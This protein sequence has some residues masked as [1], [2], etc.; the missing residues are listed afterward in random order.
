MISTKTLWRVITT[1]L[2]VLAVAGCN[3]VLRQFITPVPS[4]GGDP[5]ALSHAVVLSTNPSGNGSD[6]H[7]DVSGD[8]VAGVVTVGP[9]PVFLGKSTNQVFVLNGDNTVTQ[10]F[11]LNVLGAQSP[12]V[13]TLPSGTVAEGGGFSNSGNFYVA[14]GAGSDVSVIQA[15]VNAVTGTV[16][17]G[18]RPVAVAGNNSS[19]KI[20]VVNHDSNDV[21]AISTTDNA[22]VATIPMGAGANPIWG[23]M[24]PDGVHVFIVNSGDGISAGSVSV[25]DTLLDKV[26]ATIPV[27]VSPNYAVFESKLQRLYVSNTGSSTISVIKAN[28]TDLANGILPTKIADIKIAGNAVS[29]A[30]LSDGTRV[31]AALGGCPTGTNHTNIVQNVASCAGNQVSVIDAAALVEKGTIQV[32]AGAVSID[33]ASDASRVYVVGA[34]AGNVSIIRTADDTVL[35]TIPAPQQNLSCSNPA[36]CPAGVTQIPFMVRVF[37]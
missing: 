14:N 7:I 6:L 31:Y 5:A 19:N 25:I 9:Q 30:A 28:G 34:N 8:S 26:I 22:V 33:A 18:T 13:V 17:V 23:V 16:A 27:G 10:Y 20:Y 35:A 4:P 11:A 12:S 24:A 36:S 37:P 2:I 15:S 29:V 21:T 32:G 3:D 1:A